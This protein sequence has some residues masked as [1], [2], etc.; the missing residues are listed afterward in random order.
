MISLLLVRKIV[1]L[2]LIMILGYLLVKLK[3]LKTEESVVLSKLS[4][5]L[6]MPAVILNAF[7]VD[8]KPEIQA[9][10]TLAFVA[11]IA[12]HAVLL[13]IGHSSGKLFKFEEID[14]ASI[15]YSNAGN[16]IIPIV[17]AVLGNEWVIYSTAFVSVQLIFLWTHCKLMFSKEKK[18]N[19]RKIILNV[20]MIA[21]FVGVLSMVSGILL[22]AM[23]NE[24]LASIG[25]MIGPLG[26][27]ITGMIV[28]G[29]DM[30]QV[31]TSKKVYV[32]TFFR[33]I[34]CPAIILLLLKLSN[35]ASFVNNGTEILLITFLAT[36]TP[37]ASTVTQF[38]QVHNQDAAYAGAINIM[39]TLMCIVTMP[40]FVML[41]YM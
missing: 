27:L 32:V 23:L 9:G 33:M 24:T 2:F 3:V 16:L 4:L 39:T 20:N 14:I 18:P 34:L 11:A 38:A 35:A 12:I 22:P 41:Y 5:Y 6:V 31:F 10:L 21:I 15:I 30:K 13:V 17:T 40:L 19:L 36:V 25:S 28:A 26:M 1:Q 7:Q 8:F 37:A 29:M